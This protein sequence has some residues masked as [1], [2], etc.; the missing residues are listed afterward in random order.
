MPRWLRVVTTT[1]KER[2]VLDRL[3]GLRAKEIYARDPRNLNDI[4][5]YLA[6]RLDSPNLAERLAAS[7]TSAQGVAAVLREK[8]DGNFLYVQ[9]ALD[10]IERDQ[11]GLDDL[12]A[13]PP[14]LYGLYESFFGRHFPDEADYVD[15]RRLLEVMVAARQPL[16]ESQL[17]A[18][19]GLDRHREL[20]AVLHRLASYLSR[21]DRGDGP[22]SYTAFH[23]SLIDWLTDPELRGTRYSVVAEVGHDHLASMCWLE[24]QRGPQEMSPYA[25]SHLPA[26]LTES[27]RWDDVESLLTDIFYLEARAQAGQLFDLVADFSAA[28]LSLPE[29]RPKKRILRLLPEAL[30]RDISFIA[31][32]VHDYPQ[33][34]FQCLWNSCWWYD[35]SEAAAH[36]ETPPSG[37]TP[38]TAPWL[39][40]GKPKLCQL[41]EE[42]ERQKGERT[43]GFPWIRSLRPP[44]PSLGS[45][46]QMRL[47][48]HK[49]QP[50]RLRLT[51]DGTRMI[52]VARDGEAIVWD[53]AS[54]RQILQFFLPHY[55][56]NLSPDDLHL[57]CCGQGSVSVWRV[58]T[59]EQV[60]EWH[61]ELRSGPWF[62]RGGATI[63]GCCKD[64][65]IGEWDT[66]SGRQ[67]RQ[68][69]ADCGYV[70]DKCTMSADGKWLAFEA[71]MYD[72]HS[73]SRSFVAELCTGQLREIVSD[74]RTLS[75]LAF[76]PGSQHLAIVLADSIRIYAI[77]SLAEMSRI[78]RPERDCMLI[79]ALAFS[80]DA[81]RMLTVDHGPDRVRVWDVDSG[82]QVA[83][84][85]DYT[86]WVPFDAR[87]LADGR[88]ANLSGDCTIV[89]WDPDVP[90]TALIPI[91]HTEG[92]SSG[93]ISCVGYSGDGTLLATGGSDGTLRLWDGR[94]FHSLQRL[95][96]EWNSTVDT[97]FFSPDGRTVV[98]GAGGVKVGADSSGRK[99]RSYSFYS[100]EFRVW[101]LA[102]GDPLDHFPAAKVTEA[103]FLP[104]GRRVVSAY[105]DGTLR[106]WDLKTGDLNACL[107]GHA[108]TILTLSVSGDG[109]LLASGSR[110][111]TIR[112]WNLR[113]HEAAGIYG[114]EQD[115]APKR[116]ASSMAPKGTSFSDSEDRAFPPIPL[117]LAWL[118]GV[119]RLLCRTKDAINTWDLASATIASHIDL[120]SKV[121]AGRF[122]WNGTVIAL[123]PMDESPLWYN[124]NNGRSTVLDIGSGPTWELRWSED[125]Q[126]LVG[127]RTG[128]TWLYHLESAA[129]VDG[130]WTAPY[131]YGGSG[132]ALS[133]DSS[134]LARDTEDGVY[135]WDVRSRKLVCVL[136]GHEERVDIVQFSPLG[137]WVLTGSDDGTVRAWDVRSGECKRLFHPAQKILTRVERRWANGVDL[138]RESLD[139]RIRCG[140]PFVGSELEYWL[141]G[142]L[143][144][145][146]MHLSGEIVAAEQYGRLCAFRLEN[147][148]P[149]E[150]STSDVPGSSP[151]VTKKTSKH[152][153][154]WLR[155]LPRTC[156]NWII[157]A[158]MVFGGIYC[159]LLGGWLWLLAVPLFL[160]GT[161]FAVVG[162]LF[163]TGTWTIA[164]CP[165]CGRPALVW[166]DDVLECYRCERREPVL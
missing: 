106:F 19:T 28:T 138:E 40:E 52:S 108:D 15:V 162:V 96:A 58:D 156:C 89:V 53:L 62:S 93:Y 160:V 44:V 73:D 30:A 6:L 150:P 74:D 59:G 115:V 60:A 66:F 122:H 120:S 159:A 117:E 119:T 87:F 85:V 157:T 47:A 4:D 152:V 136:R 142:E 92:D 163:E 37:W 55:E 166:Q 84:H 16:T 102:T 34:L 20:P 101:D 13:L 153:R 90:T 39:V 158:S 104:D 141:P 147:L 24:Y 123:A 130:P 64:G 71:R 140:A 116:P 95:T 134:L 50:L 7:R 26:H 103:Q 114:N 36:Y 80:S 94:C 135:V 77:P 12:A 2:P 121:L 154:V 98:S 63:V 76:C 155:R 137:R 124:L 100:Q 45:R 61:A 139:T 128:T 10:G 17:A 14:G 129:V 99:V 11:H 97:V 86:N 25:L 79:I 111:G 112:T 126:Y 105:E 72:G 51:R 132:V 69:G 149:R 161:F 118:S 1:R 131:R 78:L 56:V 21:C 65:G 42:W 31:R 125:S 70:N 83:E 18:A 82:A 49:E 9:Q 41:L 143:G 22:T 46:V 164:R 23:R 33:G 91:D 127:A 133:P 146:E 57:A 35:C 68:V 144:K 110:D 8:C 107:K 75:A 5:R 48:G 38:A 151:G 145:H 165:L 148:P 27:R 81:K 29:D 113:T 54:G 88:V 67:L 43:P 3:R 109:S 32:R